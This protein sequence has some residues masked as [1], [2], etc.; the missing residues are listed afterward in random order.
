MCTQNNIIVVL[1]SDMNIR[2]RATSKYYY[3]MVYG[4]SVHHSQKLNKPVYAI[5]LKFVSSMMNPLAC[6]CVGM[7]RP[8]RS[9]HMCT[10]EI[11]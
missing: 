7:A 8:P 5:T 10:R 4:F 6:C 11:G 1:A 3:N 9:W 2:S